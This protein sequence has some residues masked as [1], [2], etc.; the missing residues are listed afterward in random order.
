MN[1]RKQKGNLLDMAD[2]GEF[3]VIIHGCNCFRVMGSGIARQIAL[4]YPEA[5]EADN[6]TAHASRAKLGNFSQCL[7]ENSVFGKFHILNAYTQYSCS[8]GE[9]VFEY[10][11]FDTVLNRL[12]SFL[13]KLHRDG[14]E[15][16]RVG[17]PKIG[18]GYARGKEEVIL[19]M[20]QKFSE[21]VSP[22][23]EVTLVTL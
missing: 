12:Y 19:P 2:R 20:I 17:F 23:A 7:V 16:V 3:D 11:A 6:S 1:M 5:K 22:W 8:G 15:T 13:H 18:C 10:K 14:G 21:D 4:R 9:D